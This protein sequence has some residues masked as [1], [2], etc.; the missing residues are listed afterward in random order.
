MCVGE[1]STP[2][3][4]NQPSLSYVRKPTQTTFVTMRD[5][6]VWLRFGSVSKSSVYLIHLSKHCAQIVTNCIKNTF[7]IAGKASKTP[8]KFFFFKWKW[9][10]SLLGSFVPRVLC[11]R[12][13]ETCLSFRSSGWKLSGLMTSWCWLTVCSVTFSVFQFET[14]SESL[15]EKDIGTLLRSFMIN[16]YEKN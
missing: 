12:Q 11:S 13:V 16:T 9:L 6:T 7:Y 8:F 10:Y 14:D 15:I 2:F 3:P 5:K 4:A 1:S